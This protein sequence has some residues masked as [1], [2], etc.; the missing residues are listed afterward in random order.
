[1]TPIRSPLDLMGL[2]HQKRSISILSESWLVERASIRAYFEKRPSRSLKI[3][4]SSFIIGTLVEKDACRKRRAYPKTSR[5]VKGWQMFFGGGIDLLEAFCL[6]A[7]V[8]TCAHS[9]AILEKKELTFHA[10]WESLKGTNLASVIY[11]VNETQALVLN[12]KK[13]S[14]DDGPQMKPLL[15]M[16][17]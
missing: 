16:R 8:T 6:S 15:K 11:I 12:Y 2:T 4:F 7:N 1:M 10:E 13:F 3:L 9:A 5:N 14:H 17:S